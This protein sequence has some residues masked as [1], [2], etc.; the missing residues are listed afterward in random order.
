MF[1]CC[2]FSR[3]C[4]CLVFLFVRERPP[5]WRGFVT[6]LSYYFGSITFQ[7]LREFPVWTFLAERYKTGTKNALLTLEYSRHDEHSVLFACE[8]LPS[9]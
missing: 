9:H 5:L 4:L 7:L 8:P 1:S 3:V 6:L 2:V